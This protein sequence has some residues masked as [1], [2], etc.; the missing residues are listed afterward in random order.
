M[1]GMVQEQTVEDSTPIYVVSAMTGGSRLLYFMYCSYS[2][3]INLRVGW[4]P[5]LSKALARFATDDGG[6]RF[7]FCLWDIRKG[8]ANQQ[9][10]ATR[11]V[12]RS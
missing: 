1:L 2:G 12:L 8:A 3:V 7:H 10:L 11:V 4:R 9:E 6:V 5:R